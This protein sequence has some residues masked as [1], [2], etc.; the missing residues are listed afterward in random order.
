MPSASDFGIGG[1]GFIAGLTQALDR[2]RQRREEQQL[3]LMQLMEKSGRFEMSPVMGGDLQPTN[4][5]SRLFGGPQYQSVSGQPVVPFGGAGLTLKQRDLVALDDVVNASGSFLEPDEAKA[6]RAALSPFV[7]LPKTAEN[8]RAIANATWDVLEES[9]RHRREREK[10]EAQ[11]KRERER[12]LG[13]AKRQLLGE[14]RGSIDGDMVEQIR[15]AANLD[16]LASIY[17]KLPS[18]IQQKVSEARALLPLKIEEA[19]QL[20]AA[21]QQARPARAV[22][23]EELAL[24]A[25]GGDQVADKALRLLHS[26]RRAI[27]KAGGDPDDEEIRRNLADV[28]WKAAGG[29]AQA[30]E[31][32]RLMG[33]Y[34]ATG[35]GRR[36]RG[37]RRTPEAGP[38]DHP[39]TAPGSLSGRGSFPPVPAPPPAEP[40]IKIK[41]F[42]KLD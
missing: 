5:L 17:Q 36:Q 24:R 18:P 40:E 1:L 12:E 42:R 7:G 11:D 9:R 8:A 27:G 32:L 33:E 31:T 3:A 29:D 2:A 19:R 28:A 35:P 23:R 22:T 14:L 34:K 26:A 13:I 25:A 37:E 6:L 20:E 41:S 10:Q 4:V 30:K 15:H 21:R 38:L 16:D 39:S